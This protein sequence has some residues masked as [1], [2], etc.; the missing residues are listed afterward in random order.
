MSTMAL[1]A[2][3]LTS[4]FGAPKSEMLNTFS[5][6]FNREFVEHN[7]KEVVKGTIYYRAPKK[8]IA[9]VDT[10]IEQVM[11]VIDK[12]M[13]IYYPNEKK[14]FRIK[15]KNP[16]PPP[17]IQTIIGSMKEDYG[18][19]ESGYTL[20]KHE[21]KGDTIYTYWKPPSKHKKVLGS[22]ILGTVSNKIVS[23]EAHQPD[24]RVAVKSVYRK[25]I[26]FGEKYIPREVFTEFYGESGVTQEHVI[27]S[28]VKFNPTLPD[29]V[30]NFRI[31]DSIPVKEVEF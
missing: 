2:I 20:V 18:L 13:L 5:A 31:P 15:S 11:A 23:A 17:F 24:G 21:K 30:L 9:E 22:F 19:I 26:K 25:H 29:R 28:D 8:V 7:K 14:A 10:P 4:I 12:V 16:I 3:L 6:K 1:L 27:F